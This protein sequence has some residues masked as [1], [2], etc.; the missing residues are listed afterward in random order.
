MFYLHQNLSPNDCTMQ[1]KKNYQVIQ[2]VTFLFPVG[3][4]Q[5]ALSS[6]HTSL[7]QKGHFQNCQV[8][9]GTPALFERLTRKVENESEWSKLHG[10]TMWMR[11]IP[12]FPTKGQRPAGHPNRFQTNGNSKSSILGRSEWR[13]Q[14]SKHETILWFATWQV[15]HG[16]KIFCF[17]FFRMN[18]AELV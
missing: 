5:Q 18:W 2:A 9:V 1:L 17:F 14:W 3:G 8:K 15:P 13:I 10:L 6:G 4:H 7:S 11:F 16:W 12:S